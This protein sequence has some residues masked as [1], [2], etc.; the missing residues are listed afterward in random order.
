MLQTPRAEGT[1]NLVLDWLAAGRG[2]IWQGVLVLNRT[3]AD[4]TD[5][6]RAAADAYEEHALFARRWR[7]YP[8]IAAAAYRAVIRYRP[9][10]V[11]CWTTGFGNWVSVGAFAA[12]CRRLIVHAGNP[13]VRGRGGDW[14]SRYGMWPLVAVRAKVACCSRYVR[15]EYRAIPA[16]GV[17]EFYA[18]PNCVRAGPF[19]APRGRRGGT[20]APVGLTVA[21]LESARDFTTLIR[22][23]PNVLERHP[24]FR[25]RLAGR[26]SRLGELQAE[27]ALAG[28]ADRVEFLGARGDVADLMAA[29]DVFLFPTLQEG[30]GTVLLEALLARLP[31]VANDVPACRELLAGGRWG[32]LV[33]PGDAAALA[34]AVCAALTSPAP[35]SHL[36]A[37]RAY[38]AGYTVERMTAAY[39]RLAG[40][41]AP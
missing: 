8:G 28:C 40:L 7:K 36:D 30:F 37:G 18:V 2:T 25:L 21:N 16:V 17:R 9:D 15:D 27:A 13:P 4:L 23:V 31:V 35:E 19:A 11:V 39:L 41:G 1:P 32:T 10:V 20:S 24:D 12:G 33:P 26:G 14:V 29:A 38:A 22:A 34:D 3:P 6:L 5:R